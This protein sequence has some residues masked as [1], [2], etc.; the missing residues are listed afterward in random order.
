R[1]ET[2]GDEAFWG[3][4]LRLHEAIAGS[5]NGGT[6]AG[7]SPAQALALGLKVD[8]DALGGDLRA[9]ITNGQI[10]L[11]DPATTLALLKVDSGVGVKGFFS[12]AGTL[13]SVGIE[14]ALCH[15]T[16]DDAL[17]SGIGRRRDGWGNRDLDV[18]A[19]IAL[20]PNLSPV[21]QALNTD[22][23]TVRAAVSAWGK[24]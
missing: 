8:S 9:K 15:S 2:F 4:Q 1:F 17:T 13:T 18:G 3:R 7:L 14:C 6:G 11:D 24:G 21:A 5:A 23:T 10:D 12:Q 19:I 16:V 20:A 22:E